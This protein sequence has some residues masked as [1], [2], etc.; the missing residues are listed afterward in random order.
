MQEKVK[1]LIVG[2]GLTGTW[3][4]FFLQKKGIPFKIINDPKTASATSVASGV[5]NPVTGRKIVQTW[6]IDDL[7]PFAVASYTA[8]QENKEFPIIKKAPLSGHFK[9]TK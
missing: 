8:F 4:S 7:L 6:M 3:L 9:N 5:M 1:Y 2:Q